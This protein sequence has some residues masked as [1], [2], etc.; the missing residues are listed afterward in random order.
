[1]KANTT[2][3]LVSEEQP[4]ES[5]TLSSPTPSLSP[6]MPSPVL[7]PPTQ[8]LQNLAPQTSIGLNPSTTTTRGSTTMQINTNV[9][10]VSAPRY[11]TYS[12]SEVDQLLKKQAETITGNFNSKIAL[13]QKSIQELSNALS[14]KNETIVDQ[15]RT[16]G[17]SVHKRIETAES[18]H[19]SAANENIEQTKKQL[20]KE[21]E[22]FKSYFNKQVA[23]KLK[24]IDERLSAKVPLG[25]E[26]TKSSP[27]SDQR[28][29]PLAI[30]ALILSLVNLALLFLKH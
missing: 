11:D 14:H 16:Y 28:I 12:M 26:F 20:A 3:S 9:E 8:S 5:V 18:A 6:P 10:P 7:P 27:P 1:M 24:N 19:S 29:L 15:L 13:Q 30:T 23:A 2:E 17:E 4:L 25:S 22:D 21:I